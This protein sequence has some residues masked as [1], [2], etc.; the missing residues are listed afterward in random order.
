MNHTT[1]A[2]G[3]RHSLALAGGLLAA[4]GLRAQGI[5]NP[6][7]SV[8]LVVG[9]PPGGQ[10]DFAARVIQAGLQSALGVS[11]TIDNRA[12][13]G[14]NLG[15]EAVMRARPDG[16][17]LLAGNVSPMA[18]T[19]H[20]VDG[21]TIDPRELVPVG[22]ALQCPLVLCAHPSVPVRDLAGLRAWLASQPRGAV[23]FGSTGTGSLTHLAMEMLRDRLGEPEMTHLSYRGSTAALQEFTGGRFSLMFERASVVAPYLRA[24]QLRG[25]LVTS[26]S[27]AFPD[28]ATAEDEGLANFA[29]RSWIGL[30]APR[31][32]A[33]EVV[34]RMNAALNT[35][36]AEMAARERIALRLEEP[37]GGTPEALGQLMAQDYARWGEVVRAHHIRAD[38]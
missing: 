28:I 5:W 21:M 36:L 15:T 19:P 32:T 1:T 24:R 29:F 11:V 4:P 3:R 34:T 2:I 18:I 9:F 17:T 7:R 26:R 16:Y 13:E 20:T 14:G 25:I 8:T 10:T 27:A 35:A 6:T 38:T 12:G 30:F 23:H 22:I 31:G 37:G 33:P